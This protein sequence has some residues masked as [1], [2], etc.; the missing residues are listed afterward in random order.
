MSLTMI[1]DDNK[2]SPK[3]ELHRKSSKNFLPTLRIVTHVRGGERNQEKCS[4]QA[5]T[6]WADVCNPLDDDGSRSKVAGFSFAKENSISAQEK[7]KVRHKSEVTKVRREF[8]FLKSGAIFNK[9]R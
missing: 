3:S 2:L 9:D 1:L 6:R 4:H 7:N 8:T 5:W